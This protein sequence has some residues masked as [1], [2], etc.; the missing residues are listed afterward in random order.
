MSRQSCQSSAHSLFFLP[1]F[2]HP[3]PKTG[4][5]PPIHS[6]DRVL[7]LEK[8]IHCDSRQP[9]PSKIDMT[10][11]RSALV[12]SIDGLSARML[13]PYANTWFSTHQFDRLAAQSLLM[14]FA[15]T[16]CPT[17]EG[18]L[19]SLW[20]KA[21]AFSTLTDSQAKN[22]LV[23][24]LA[25]LGVES[26][27]FTDEP[28]LPDLPIANEFDRLIVPAHEQ[29]SDSASDPSETALAEFFAA[30]IEQAALLADGELLWLH[31]RGLHGPWD[32]PY[33]MRCQFA[34]PEDPEPPTFF[35][36]P[37]R[38]PS[39]E[40]IDP[41]ELLGYQQACAAQVVLIDQFLGILLDYLE[42]LPKSQQPLFVLTAPRGFPM[43][44]GGYVGETHK[45]LYDESIHVPLI[46][47]SPDGRN[48]L[49]RN[50]QLVYSSCL[51]GMVTQWMGGDSEDLS[52]LNNPL[53]KTEHEMILSANQTGMSVRTQNWKLIQQDQT[54]Q[55]FVKPDDRW[56]RNDVSRKC[57]WITEELTEISAR[58]RSQIEESGQF[59]P[60]ELPDTLT[61]S[62]S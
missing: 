62:H 11:K 29:L 35:E 32:A 20:N 56:E 21:P 31:S 59:E 5:E 49:N 7:S 13:G 10:A 38:F 30:G 19:Q 47:R 8:P 15:F 50:Q 14:E 46:V 24:D 43:G 58:M 48:Q 1:Q 3:L 52:W 12:L 45:T 54:Q 37:S 61:V 55:L 25:E 23:L 28:Q 51:G 27:L 9:D 36:T 39:Q 44:A 18:S 4:S 22:R 6:E 33:D 16:D 57:R 53:P 60:F 40:E 42:S 17:L 2:A 34:D 26:T 41:D